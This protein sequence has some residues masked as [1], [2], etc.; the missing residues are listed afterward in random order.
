MRT[1]SLSLALS[2]LGANAAFA[3]PITGR[4]ADTLPKDV[5]QFDPGGDARH[6]ATNWSC[7]VMLGDLPRDQIVVYDQVGL[8][9]SCGYLKGTTSITL[10]L[11]RGSGNPLDAIMEVVKG[12][13]VQRLPEAT[14][15]PDAEQR[16][17]ESAQS[18]R[19]FIYSYHNGDEYTGA[20]VGDVS[21]W[22]MEIRADYARPDQDKVFALLSS[23]GNAAV[24]TAGAYLDTCAAAAKVSRSGKAMS[25]K[26]KVMALSLVAGIGTEEEAKAVPAPETWCVEKTLPES[27]SLVFWRNI[28]NDDRAGNRDRLTVGMGDKRR[29]VVSTWDGTLS[30]INSELQ[31]DAPVVYV[32]TLT[33]GNR[34][35]V[36]GFYEGRPDEETLATLARDVLTG[37]SRPVSSYERGSNTLNITVP[38]DAK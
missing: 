30:V 8:D 21:G 9:V 6:A 15:L 18:W 17:F 29:V 23:A 38:S 31:K 11:T 16:T 19:H 35:F 33:Q 25:D 28:A 32:A 4:D 2:L 3:D 22:T 5:W 20:W 37:K 34:V 24:Q 1:V 13:I 7:P 26:D 36:L 14:P 10:Y 12:G 27:G